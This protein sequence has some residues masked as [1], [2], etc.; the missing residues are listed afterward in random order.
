MPSIV[1][2]WENGL[3]IDLHYMDFGS[4][5]P[6]VLVQGELGPPDCWR[7]QRRLL[8]INGYRTVDYFGRTSLG[9][10]AGRD[11]IDLDTRADDFQLIFGSLR[12]AR[13]TVMASSWRCHE[14]LRA[15]ATHGDL[16][17]RSIVLV[18]PPAATSDQVSIEC[19]RQTFDDAA[20]V[21]VPVLLVVGEQHLERGPT[22]LPS[23]YAPR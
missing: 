23:R 22:S 4:G 5:R 9:S 15:L 17:I 13:A 21:G 20:R 12:L 16:Q 7:R 11:S 1:A 19:R 3:R 8:H 10:A 14:V 6:V 2:G 18:S